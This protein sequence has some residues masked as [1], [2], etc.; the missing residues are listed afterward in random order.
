MT[1][2]HAQLSPSKAYR[3]LACPGSVREEARYPEP[4]SGPGA[5]DGT[6]SHTLLEHCI[7]GNG[8]PL[9]MIGVK[10]K[11]HE[12]EFTVDAERAGRTREVSVRLAGAQGCVGSLAHMRSLAA[13]YIA[14]PQT[15]F[16]FRWTSRPMNP[17]LSL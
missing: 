13:W 5:I 12:G 15:G 14:R 6:H 10:L 2:T 11:D 4:P 7:K 9:K 1:T 16:R 8:D 3:Y 17:Y